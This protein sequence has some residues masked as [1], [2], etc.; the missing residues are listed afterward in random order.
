[1]QL[2]EISLDAFVSWLCSHEHEVIGLSGKC[3]DDPL[4]RWL[5]EM[6][7]HVFGV[8]GKWYGRASSE[9]GRWRLLPRWAEVF[10]VWMES[11][12]YRPITGIEALDV[13]AQVELVVGSKGVRQACSA[14]A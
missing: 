8:D 2:V 6:T 3:F 1:M 14:A 9:Y 11:R 13:L 5:S 10:C 7:G 4:A 12:A